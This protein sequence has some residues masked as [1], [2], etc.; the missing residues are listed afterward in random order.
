MIGDHNGILQRAYYYGQYKTVGY[1]WIATNVCAYDYRGEFSGQIYKRT[2]P[3]LFKKELKKTG[4]Q[5]Y[6]QKRKYTRPR[7]IPFRIQQVSLH[8][9]ACKG[10]FGTVD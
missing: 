2:L 5:E 6:Y 7:E 9:I 10:G 8:G 1:R 4:L 3:S